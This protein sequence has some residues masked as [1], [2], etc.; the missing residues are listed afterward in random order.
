MN[1]ER[2]FKMK[3]KLTVL[4]VDDEDLLL[5]YLAL[6]QYYRASGAPCKALSDRGIISEDQSEKAILER[7]FGRWRVSEIKSEEMI[8]KGEAIPAADF[9]SPWKDALEEYFEAFMLFFFPHIH[10]EIDWSK[11]HVFLDK[12]FQ[13]IVRDAATGRRYVDKLVKV[14]LLGGLETWLLIHVEVQ[15]TYER[16]FQKRLFTYNNRI[17]DTYDVEVVSLAILTDDNPSWRPDHFRTERWGCEHLFRFPTVKLIDLGRDWSA[18]EQNPNPFS[19]VVMA[20]L[21]TQEVKDGEERERWKLYLV[22]LL[23]K[24]GYERKDILELFRFIDWLLVLPAGLEKRFRQECSALEEEKQMP[25]VTSIERL[26]KEE[27]KEEGIQIGALQEARENVL[28][29]LDARFKTVPDDVVLA[30][31]GMETREIL[32]A[33]HRQAITCDSLE[34]FREGL[35]RTVG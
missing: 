28:E 31:Q 29:A 11:G 24:R 19:I 21:K 7:S 30:L 25:Y 8:G 3:E 20:H 33:L 17:T 34:A 26:A 23:Y 4:I 22:R 27:G 32:K 2:I 1:S 6:S 35:R 14:F 16:L 15:G 13:E 18:L 9:D 10:A 12:E 5:D